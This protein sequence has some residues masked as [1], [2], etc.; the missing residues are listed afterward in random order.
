M[1]TLPKKQREDTLFD[2]DIDIEL[3]LKATENAEKE[4][5]SYEW[6][7]RKCW[8]GQWIRVQVVLV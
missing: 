2:E 8:G 1:S 4:G 3:L 6:H 5:S 7:K